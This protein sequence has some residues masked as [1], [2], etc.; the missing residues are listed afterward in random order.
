VSTLLPYVENDPQQL[1]R[2]CHIG[3]DIL[4]I[5]FQGTILKTFFIDEKSLTG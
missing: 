1:Q 2:K 5:V 3:N 4:A